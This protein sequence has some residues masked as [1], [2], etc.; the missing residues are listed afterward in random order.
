[1]CEWVSEVVS[2][3]VNSERQFRRL[4]PNWLNFY[5]MRSIPLFL[6]E[7]LARW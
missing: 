5:P 1:M 4:K 3:I 7:V 6:A 2:G